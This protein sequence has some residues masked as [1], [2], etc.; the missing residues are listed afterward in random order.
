MPRDAPRRVVGLDEARRRHGPRVDDIAALH[1]VGD[2]DWPVDE[3]PPTVPPPSWLD[4]DR[5]D[6]GGA[7]LRRFGVATSA[8]LRVYALPLSYLSPAGVRPLGATRALI[9]QAGPRVYRTADYVLE[10]HQRGALHPD[11]PHWRTAA[12]VRTQHARVRRLLWSRGWD[13]AD[14]APLPQP[15][16]A[17]TALLFGP[18]TVDGLRRLGAPIRD[19]EADDVAHLARAMAYGQG[20]VPRLWADRHDDAL[21]LFAAITSLDG[22]PSDTG[23]DLM[24]ALLDIPHTLGRTRLDRLLAPLLSHSYRSLSVHLLGPEHA[25]ALGIEGRGRLGRAL[26]RLVPGPHHHRALTPVHDA[27]VAAITRRGQARMNHP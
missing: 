23:R 16:L 1:H 24:A 4:P 15:D 3:A 21:E 8:V 2:P 11:G 22:P 25:R 27:V 12:T 14:G 18:I 13:P 7:V 5:C 20:V 26:G 10:T 6:R 9:D 17:A 19:D